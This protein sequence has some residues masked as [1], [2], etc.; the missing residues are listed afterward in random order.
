MG[1]TNVTERTAST[2]KLAKKRAKQDRLANDMV[3]S[4]LEREGM[5]IIERDWHCKEG[6]VQ[7]IA[8]ENDDL[9][10]I[11]VRSRSSATNGFP[12]E[13]VTREKRRKIEMIACAYL[14]AG[15]LPSSRVRFDVI[16][17]LVDEASG[18]A[19]MRVHRDAFCEAE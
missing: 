16:A 14:F 12:E 19:F 17:V 1:N 15:K 10:F 13:A 7:F 18:M 4:F 5:K 9:V 3:G 2:S 8:I 11:E 6:T